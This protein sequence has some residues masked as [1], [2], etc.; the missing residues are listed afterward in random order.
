MSVEA[1]S[2]ACLKHGPTNLKLA[3]DELVNVHD[4]GGSLNVHKKEARGG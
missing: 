4:N 3:L 2:Q 1:M